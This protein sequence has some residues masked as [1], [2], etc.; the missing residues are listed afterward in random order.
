MRSYRQFKAK[1]GPLDCVQKN[2]QIS[3]RKESAVENPLEFDRTLTVAV[4]FANRLQKNIK[5]IEKWAK[6]Q[7][8]DAYRLYEMQNKE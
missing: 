7:G 6:Q 5:K 8:L 1:N 4:D 2:Y 3:E